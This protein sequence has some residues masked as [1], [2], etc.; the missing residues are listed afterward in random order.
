MKQYL[1]DAILQIKD[2]YLQEL[3]IEYIEDLEEYIDQ[4]IQD[5]DYE[6]RDYNLEK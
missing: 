2:E 1:F 3:I 6:I 4:L 5:V